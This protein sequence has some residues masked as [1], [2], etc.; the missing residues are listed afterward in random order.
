[1]QRAGRQ[2]LVTGL[3]TAGI[4]VLAL[5]LLPSELFF[6]ASLVVIG[7]AAWEYVDIIRF[8][9]P[10]APLRAV[11]PLFGC[12]AVGLY[13]ALRL[14]PAA[15]LA[16][17]LMLGVGTVIILGAAGCSLFF[18][19]EVRDA[20]AG[21]GLIAFGALY[22]ALPTVSL[23][24]LQKFDP[25]LVF[26]LFAIVGLGDTAAYYVG[27]RIGRHKLAPVISPNKSW[28]G[29]LA[30][31]LAALIVTV[32]WSLARRGEISIPLLLVAG[33]TAVMA[34]MGDLTESLIKRGAGVKDSS[35]I[36][37]GHGGLFDRLDA[38][39]LAAPTFLLGVWLIGLARH[40]G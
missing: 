23:S 10:S 20:V 5:F 17:M 31:L 22:F 34:Q 33:A 28:E 18:R 38:V 16:G 7:R 25:W 12:V 4:A 30:G 3:A 1:M 29:S 8:W 13:G 6:A 14:A 21:M 40:A 24:V 35:H 9:A 19:A 39:L 32:A 27:S 11:I 36:L 37:P 2:R 15:H 26:L